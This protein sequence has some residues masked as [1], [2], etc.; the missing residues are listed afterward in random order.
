MCA[1]V[2]EQ[3]ILGIGRRLMLQKDQPEL[4]T[5]KCASIGKGFN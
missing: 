3:D 2:L 1:F 5:S 4:Y